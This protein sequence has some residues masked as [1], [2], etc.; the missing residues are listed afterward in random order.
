MKINKDPQIVI[1]DKD[2]YDNLRYL[3][4]VGAEESGDWDLYENMTRH[5]R[6]FNEDI[7]TQHIEAIVNYVKNKKE[8]KKKAYSFIKKYKGKDV[9]QE[10][11]IPALT[12]RHDAL[13]KITIFDIVP[14]NKERIIVH[15]SDGRYKQ[16]DVHINDI[17]DYIIDT[18]PEG[19]FEHTLPNGKLYYLRSKEP[20]IPE[21]D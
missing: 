14:N 20:V 8:N 2:V 11:A 10:V 5:V 1:M 19:Y 3:A 6:K 12:D 16:D 13:I 7:K 4:S 18:L 9:Y 17:H 15:Y 21:W